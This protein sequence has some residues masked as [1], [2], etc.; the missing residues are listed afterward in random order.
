MTAQTATHGVFDM[1]RSLESF[2]HEIASDASDLRTH[3]AHF[4]VHGPAG[5]AYIRQ[6]DEGLRGPKGAPRAETPE[7]LS[8]IIEGQVR[9][10]SLDELCREQLGVEDGEYTASDAL[11]CGQGVLELLRGRPVLDPDPDAPLD[12]WITPVDLISAA[13]ALQ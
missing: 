1:L 2:A 6:D 4:A 10:A 11:I 7:D 9:Y 3:T 5:W 8:D 12:E 13:E